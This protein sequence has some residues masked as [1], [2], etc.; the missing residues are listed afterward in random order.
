MGYHYYST[1]D[2]QQGLPQ[3]HRRLCLLARSLIGYLAVLEETS[4]DKLVNCHSFILMQNIVD[5]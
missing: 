2:H 1:V 4:K 5:L 3:R